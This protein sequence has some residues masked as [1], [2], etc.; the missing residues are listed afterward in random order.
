MS[1]INRLRI[2]RRGAMIFVGIILLGIIVAYGASF[3]KERG[4]QARREQA[5]SQAEEALSKQTDTAVEVATDVSGQDRPEEVPVTGTTGSLPQTGVGDV[6][7]VV[8][9]ALLTA[10]VAYYTM[11]R[12]AV[13]TLDISV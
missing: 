9:L 3:L 12:R 6:Y 8:V 2:T 1:S 5:I 11:S 4:E 7:A 10:S 13:K